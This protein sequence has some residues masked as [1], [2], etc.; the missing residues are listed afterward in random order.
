LNTHI[1]G[2]I[3]SFIIIFMYTI[4]GV[5][6]KTLIMKLKHT[7]ISNKHFK[8]TINKIPNTTNTTTKKNVEYFM[9]QVSRKVL[10]TMTKDYLWI[11]TFESTSSTKKLTSQ[12]VASKDQFVNAQKQQKQQQ[13]QQQQSTTSS[14]SASLSG[15]V[16]GIGGL[17]ASSSSQN[18]SQQ[19]AGIT[20]SIENE[21]TIPTSNDTITAATTKQKTM[22][23]NSTTGTTNNN[24][25][26]IEWT[27]AIEQLSNINT[28]QIV[29]QAIHDVKKCI[30]SS[31]TL[32][33][34]S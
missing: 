11:R 9:S 4:N 22:K 16:A 5:H 8:Q 31:N 14:S 30:F 33:S 15:V 23:H 18:S 1:C 29:H 19:Q 21:T 6:L 3:L 25:N 17:K 28:E 26:T 24:M 20:S 32:S 12:L 13:Q 7:N 34:S 10:E 27:K 2:S